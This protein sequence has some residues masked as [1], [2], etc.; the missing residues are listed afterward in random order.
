MF[1][2]W[3]SHPRSVPGFGI[4]HSS[5]RSPP[6]RLDLDLDF[7]LAESLTLLLFC[8]FLALAELRP[9]DCERISDFCC[10]LTG[11]RDGCFS[12]PSWCARLAGRY[13]AAVPDLA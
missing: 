7:D 4:L 1:S 10:C 6:G 3:L 8:A 5:R 13:L 9:R 12:S 11:D 2:G